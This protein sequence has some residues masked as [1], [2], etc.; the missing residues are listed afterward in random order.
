MTERKKRFPRITLFNARP[1]YDEPDNDYFYFADAD[2]HP[3]AARN[4]FDPDASGFSPVNAWWLSEAATL[5][6][7]DEGTVRDIFRRKTPLHEFR[8]FSV[9]GTQCFV[10]WNQEFAIVA[11]RGTEISPRKGS[12][13]D[14][15]EIHRDI[16]TDADIRTSDFGD[17][18]H[19]HRGFA[20]QFELV[21]E[22]EGLGAFV[23]DLPARTVWFTGHSLGAALAT[24]AAARAERINGLYTFGSPRVGD[25][26]FAV[27]LVNR[28][29]GRGLEHYRFVNGSDLVTT[30]P[31]TTFPPTISFKHTGTLR[32]FPGV[33]SFSTINGIPSSL[34]DHIPTIYAT[35][36][37]NAYV[38]EQG[39]GN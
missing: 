16:V 6:Y 23:R 7:S 32:E 21:W 30:V 1:P 9:G 28:L 34:E 13:R 14:F 37:W 33:R 12:R 8:A 18:T 39:G 27:A 20:E 29:A 17:G 24:L 5:V 3:T 10:A 19:V 4:P 36:L 2:R 11:F 26:A 38:E 25:E 22:G 15:S 35:H 31:V